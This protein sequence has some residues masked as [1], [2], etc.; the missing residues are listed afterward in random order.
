[1]QIERSRLTAGQR[2]SAQSELGKVVR[3]ARALS[4]NRAGRKTR[5]YSHGRQHK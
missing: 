5:Q 1:M 3:A 2:A 4:V